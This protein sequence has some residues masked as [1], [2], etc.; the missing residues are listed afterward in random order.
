MTSPKFKLASLL[1][2]LAGF[3]SMASAYIF[4]SAD[5]KISGKELHFIHQFSESGAEA[6]KAYCDIIDGWWEHYKPSSHGSAIGFACTGSID[7][8]ER[9]C[10]FGETMKEVNASFREQCQTRYTVEDIKW[11]S[12]SS[13]IIMNVGC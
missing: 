11:Y 7:R 12:Y 6:S 2:S 8:T 3:P 13:A 10:A 1:F 4:C 9:V 5:C